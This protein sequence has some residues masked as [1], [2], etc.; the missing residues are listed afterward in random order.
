MG[1][2]N[3][4]VKDVDTGDLTDMKT[5]IANNSGTFIETQNLDVVAQFPTDANG[6]AFAVDAA[7]VGVGYTNIVW[8]LHPAIEQRHG[9]L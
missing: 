5:A 7:G 1:T 9:N 3:A 4:I 8:D 6:A 2:R